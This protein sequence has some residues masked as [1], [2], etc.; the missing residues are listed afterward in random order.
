MTWLMF[1]LLFTIIVTMSRYYTNDTLLDLNKVL[2][3]NPAYIKATVAFL[4]VGQ[5]F[6]LF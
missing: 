5:R 2:I 6:L 1:S 3:K 4:A